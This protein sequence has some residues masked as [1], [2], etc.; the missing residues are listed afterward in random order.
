MW[1]FKKYVN[2]LCRE[3]KNILKEQNEEYLEYTKDEEESFI[4]TVLD[5]KVN[6]TI[7]CYDV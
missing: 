3:V 6:G 2:R 1:I 5:G 7:F 4:E